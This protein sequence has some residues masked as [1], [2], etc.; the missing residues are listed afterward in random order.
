MKEEKEARSDLLEKNTI[1]RAYT[2]YNIN[3]VLG[4][5]FIYI[6]KRSNEGTLW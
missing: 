3:T 6:L 4:F 5:H 1:S 2:K